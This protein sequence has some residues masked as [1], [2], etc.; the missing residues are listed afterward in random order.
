M[1]NLILSLKK[2]IHPDPNEMVKNSAPFFCS[3]GDFFREMNRERE[4]S[5]RSGL[6]FSILVLSFSNN[7]SYQSDIQFLNDYLSKRLRA[8]D[9]V[10]WLDKYSLGITMFNTLPDGARV[11]ADE[12]H[13]MFLTAKRTPPEIMSYVYPDEPIKIPAY[14]E[15]FRREI[16]IERERADRSGLPFAMLIFHIERTEAYQLDATLLKD[17]LSKRLRATDSV[18]WVDDYNIGI[19]MFNTL[20]KGARVLA[21]EIHHIFKDKGRTPPEMRIFFYQNEDLKIIPYGANNGN[22]EKIAFERPN[23]EEHL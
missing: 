13:Q 1:A 23:G 9:N 14:Q 17:F 19:T 12:I 22:I 7:I 21:D 20:P 8:T 11:L 16:R 15:D 3:K 4:R 10:G 6:P 2:L 18:G 5:N